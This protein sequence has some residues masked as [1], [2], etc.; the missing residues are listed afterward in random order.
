MNITA[1]I[2]I[3]SLAQFIDV[4]E[5]ARQGICLD[6]EKTRDIIRL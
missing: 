4:T 6:F 1:M 5:H 2:G 3:E